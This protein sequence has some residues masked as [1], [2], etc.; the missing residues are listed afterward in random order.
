[1]RASLP[2]APA[3][4]V[5]TA[6]KK[7]PGRLAGRENLAGLAAGA[8]SGFACS[9]AFAPVDAGPL[10]FVALVPLCLFFRRARPRPLIVASAALGLTFFGALIYWIRLFGGLA[11]VALVLV[12]TLWVVGSLLLGRKLRDSLPS[13]WGF[14]ALP[15]AFLIGE[16]ARSHLPWD[17]FSWGGLGYTQHNNLT[18]L[19]LASYTGVWGLTLCILL[20]NSLLAEGVSR[21][22]ESPSAA[23]KWGAAALVV[24]IFPALLPVGRPEGRSARIA[25]VQGNVPE[26]TIDPNSDDQIVLDNHVGLTNRIDSKGISLIVWAEGAFD[27]DPFGD[28]AFK[29]TLE[30][31]IQRAGVPF[32]I[33]A[34]LD[35]SGGGGPRNTTL[36]FDGQARLKGVYTKQRLVPFGEWVPLRSFLQPMVHELDR[37][38]VDLTSGHESTVFSIPEGRFA[39]V[40]CYES[41]YPD[42]VRSFVR[43][44][45]R[46]LVV[47]TNFSSYNRTAA[48]EQ[49]IAFSQLRAA[50][51]RMWV[52]HT[53]VSGI[54][55][56]VAPDGRVV[57]RTGLFT[58]QV[59]TPKI[60]FATSTTVYA[61]LGDWLPLAAIV[62]AI[63][64]LASGLIKALKPS[65]G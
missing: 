20:I 34:I 31:T 55:A 61:R 23:A 39:S 29:S 30:S 37:I 62:F 8:A 51:H 60:R 16:F 22:R 2:I 13:R 14:V 21:L 47:S 43:N 3:S 38:P 10:A 11:Y 58:K 28:P 4:S 7:L 1:M 15:V 53:A 12:Q 19:R 63:G 41:T 46:L 48:S 25:M 9:L 56:V 18:M 36:F 40:I 6:F 5:E 57:Q 52:A 26:N 17:G 24:A 44:G 59:L 65:A 42:L 35:A 33:G 54:S 27:R 45:A 32:I 64:V 49:H 50:E